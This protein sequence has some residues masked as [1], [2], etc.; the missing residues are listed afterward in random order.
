M[1]T[2]YGALIQHEPTSDSIWYKVHDD[3][4]LNN[5]ATGI[6]TALVQGVAKSRLAQYICVLCYNV[7]LS[8][9]GPDILALDSSN[10]YSNPAKVIYDMMKASEDAYPPVE[11]AL[12]DCMAPSTAMLNGLRPFLDPDIRERIYGG[13]WFDIAGAGCL[14]LLREIHK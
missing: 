9:F 4:K 2:L 7:T 8:T 3:V 12:A 10:T 5:T 13:D 11:Y 1:N 6:R 14:Q